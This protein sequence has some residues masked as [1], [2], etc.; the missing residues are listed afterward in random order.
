MTTRSWPVISL[1]TALAFCVSCPL[2]ASADN[3]TFCY[4]QFEHSLSNVYSVLPEIFDWQVQYLQQSGVPVISL[5]EFNRRYF[6]KKDLGQ[7]ALLTVDDG[8]ADVREVLPV[9]RER[10]APLTL[11][12]Y[13][14]VLQGH[15]RAYLSAA[16]LPDLEKEPLL[17][18]GCHSYTHP[19]LRHQSSRGMRREVVTSQAWL[20][21]RLNRKVDDFAYPYGMFD[22]KTKRA[23]AQHY[24][25]AFGVDDGPNTVA[26]DPYNLRRFVVYRT[27]TMGEFIDMAQSAKGNA[28]RSYRI[29]S[30]G[31]GRGTNKHFV[32]IKAQLYQYPETPKTKK[33]LVIPGSDI[34]AAW[35][36]KMVDRLVQRDAEVVVMVNR[37]NN[38]P[39]YRP[40]K[41][42]NTLLSWGLDEYVED[43]KETLD[44]LDVEK[45]DWA[46]I[47]WGDGFDL[48]AVTLARY[49]D[50][51]QHLKGMAALNPSILAPDG[52]TP[53]A[54][55]AEVKHYD[56]QLA[57][58]EYASLKLN[59][60][61]KI[62]TLADLMVLNPDLPSPFAV[63]LGYPAGMT[64]KQLLVEEL[65][66]EDHPDLGLDYASAHYTVEDFKAAFM[67]PVPL[68]S[69]VVPLRWLRDIHELWATDFQQAAIRKSQWVLPVL[70]LVSADYEPNLDRIQKT[71]PKLRLERHKVFTDLSTIELLL[72]D[73]AADSVTAAVGNYLE[74]PPAPAPAVA[75][76]AKTQ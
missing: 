68:F 26:R 11:F 19:V 36:H 18:F 61:L 44:Y 58:G 47:T 40:I 57:A 29:K 25:M 6:E 67:R 52:D 4:H 1:L 10:K 16:Q 76:P 63:K 8:W 49:P 75:E 59:V 48:L 22:R 13:P 73:A 27:T 34:G 45:T 37:N 14:S 7:T 65:D 72:S 32:Y 53:A 35:M 30:L 41:E 56:A 62:K 21:T 12:L 69:M 5:E 2:P 55:A 33:V 17:S 9:I 43:L 20:E 74:L 31:Y 70:T 38:I 46:V 39:F 23:V 64:N 60:F 50:Y 54:F 28:P 24:Q 3:V 71:F 42:M 15:S 66:K 51:A